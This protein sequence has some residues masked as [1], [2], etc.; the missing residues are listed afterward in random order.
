MGNSGW[1]VAVQP[2]LGQHNPGR[3]PRSRTDLARRGRSP[4]CDRAPQLDLEPALLSAVIATSG[5]H[6]LGRLRR[7][8]GARCALSPRSS[9]AA[10]STAI[11]ACVWASSNAGFGWLPFWGRRMD[12]P[13]AYVGST[14]E[15]KRRPSEYLTSGRFFCSIERAEGEDMFNTV[16][17]FSRRRGADVRPVGL[18][19]TP[20]ASSR[21]RSTMFWPGRASTPRSGKS[22]SGATRPAS[23]SRSETVVPGDGGLA[24]V[25]LY[26]CA[27]LNRRERAMIV[28]QIWTANAGRNFNYLIAC[29]ETGE[30]LAIDPLDHEKCLTAAK[31]KGWNIT[32]VL[33]THEHRDHTGGND[34]GDRRDTRQTA[35]AC[36]RQGP[37]RRH[38]PRPQGRR[39][40]QDRARPSSS[41]AST[42]RATRCRISCVLAHGDKAAVVLRRHAVQPPVLQ[43]P[44]MAGIRTSSTT[45]CATQ[46]SEIA[47][48][49][50]D[51]SRSRLHRAQSQLHLRPRSSQDN[52]SSTRRCSGRDG[53]AGHDQALVTTL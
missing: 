12:E 42:R 6:F 46:L 40:D 1:A 19:H 13:Y 36:R 26:S 3:S 2:S 49:D 28:E 30:A 37:H 50:A 22:C 15:L 31:A 27:G 32:Q 7:I 17:R 53:T 23:S 10:F 45:P 39:R 29:A 47:G 18:I 5:T 11:R 48:R 51:L 44:P 34:P 16:T 21:S 4:I 24:G 20:S 25:V 38:R 43:L 33:N 14:A 52:A 8:P 41:N 35:G 9:A